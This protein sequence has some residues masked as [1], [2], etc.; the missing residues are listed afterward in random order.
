MTE[1]QN[2]YPWK[3]ENEYNYEIFKYEKYNPITGKSAKHFNRVQ[4][5]ILAID[6]DE[7]LGTFTPYLFMLHSIGIDY[8]VNKYSLIKAIVENMLEDGIIRPHIKKLFKHIYKLKKSNKIDRVVMYTSCG[9]NNNY[10]YFLKDCIE[11]YTDCIGIYDDVIHRDNVYANFL[12]N[13][14]M[15][16]NFINLISNVNRKDI[17]TLGNFYNN[18]DINQLS[19]S[20]MMIDDHPENVIAYNGSNVKIEPYIVFN[21]YSVRY[22][23]Q[24]FIN[25]ILSVNKL[26]KILTN[27]M[28]KNYLKLIGNTIKQL[29]PTNNNRSI[30]ISPQ[31]KKIDNSLIHILKMIDEKYNVKYKSKNIELK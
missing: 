9:N 20:I 6:N 18:T 27:E 26:K 22:L 30:A 12:S 14:R 19:E 28:I 2:L 31:K 16:K 8:K 15:E 5:N 21:Y 7:T 1:V 3:Y 17:H 10:I 11:I 24:K 29:Y 25:T 23:N 4:T 13:G